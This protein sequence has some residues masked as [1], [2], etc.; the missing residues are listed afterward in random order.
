[1]MISYIYLLVNV[2]LC[3]VFNIPKYVMTMNSQ[4]FLTKFVIYFPFSFFAIFG[5]CEVHYKEFNYIIHIS[6]FSSFIAV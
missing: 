4:L 3:T 6:K 2:M 5:V 1:M